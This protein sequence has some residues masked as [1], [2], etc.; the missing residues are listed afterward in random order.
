MPS[1]TDVTC[2]G[3]G[4]EVMIVSCVWNVSERGWRELQM[5]RW[6]G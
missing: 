6:R 1:K 2:E 3:S 5:E 4:R